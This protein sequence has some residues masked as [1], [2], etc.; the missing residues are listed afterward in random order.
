VVAARVGEESGVSSG[1]A[2][3]VSSLCVCV[4]VFFFCFTR[5]RGGVLLCLCVILFMCVVFVSAKK[6]EDK[7]GEGVCV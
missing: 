4:R 2:M 6:V 7:V 5:E 1:V 3:V